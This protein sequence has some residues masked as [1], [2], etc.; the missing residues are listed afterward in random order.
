MLFGIRTKPFHAHRAIV[1]ARALCRLPTL[2]W[3]RGFGE[4]TPRPAF[5]STSSNAGLFVFCL[6]LLPVPPLF[7]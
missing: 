6:S 2:F 4:T 1:Q 5:Y 3:K 7:V